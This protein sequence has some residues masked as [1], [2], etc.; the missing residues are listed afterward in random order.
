MKH[1]LSVTC[2]EWFWRKKVELFEHTLKKDH[3]NSVITDG[4]QYNKSVGSQVEFWILL[5]CTK[6]IL[7]YWAF[8][9]LF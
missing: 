3:G 2:Q 1:S 6:D 4:S 9:E 5:L 7:L 8:W